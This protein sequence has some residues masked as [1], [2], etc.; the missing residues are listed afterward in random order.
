MHVDP[1]LYIAS[2]ISDA[3]KSLWD[4]PKRTTTHPYT[5]D[6]QYVYVCFEVFRLRLV[7]LSA[8]KK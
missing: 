6:A 2:Q 5:A 3:I 7:Q 4:P 8:I 1:V